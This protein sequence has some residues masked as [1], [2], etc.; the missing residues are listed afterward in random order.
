LNIKRSFN[1]SFINDVLQH[2][3]VKPG[4]EVKGLADLQPI[5]DNLE[6]FL[7]VTEHGGFLLVN[8]SMG[9]YELHTQFLP[10]GRGKHVVDSG[11]EAFQYM[12]LN[13][14][15]TRVITK[16]SPTN[17]SA[18]NLSD[19]F[20]TCRGFNQGYHYYSCDI[21]QWIERDEVVKQA[22]EEFHEIAEETTNH[23]DD[24]THDA[25]AGFA[26]LMAKN[27]N[28]DKGQYVYNRWAVMS[29]YEVIII[30]QRQ[31]LVAK[32]G[33][34]RLTIENGEVICQQER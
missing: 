24:A 17:V 1:A 23:N 26:Y 20:F 6:N 4:A 11:I 5:I 33:Y 28:F 34:M 8:R 22:G 27:G 30:E 16:A 3:E 10:S 31:P 12:F 19:A 25:Y 9:V 18:K 15:C 2:P 14:D 29:N 21:E 13:T 7:L 32:I